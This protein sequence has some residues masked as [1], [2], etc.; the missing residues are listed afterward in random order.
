MHHQEI[1]T[2]TELR[3]S[4]PATAARFGFTLIELLVVI[5]I[6]AIL[7]AILVP[8]VTRAL[9]TARMTLSLSNQKQIG[10]LFVAYANDHEGML[11]PIRGISGGAYG[12]DPN[13]RYWFWHLY[14]YLDDPGDDSYVHDEQWMNSVFV[15]PNFPWVDIENWRLGYAMNA[16]IPMVVHEAPWQIAVLLQVDTI[17]IEDPSTTTVVATSDDWHYGL[18]PGGNWEV[19][20]LFNL[21]NNDKAPILFVDGHVAAMEYDQYSDDYSYYPEHPSDRR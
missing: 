4:R 21:Y 18:H 19:K 5:A 17:S 15:C 7:A 20:P 3:K 8:A 12:E 14:K 11:P 2:M 13:Y 1:L 9:D 6:I 16:R 10:L